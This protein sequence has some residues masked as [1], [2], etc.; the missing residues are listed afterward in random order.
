MGIKLYQEV[1]VDKLYISE[2]QAL[3]GVHVSGDGRARSATLEHGTDPG[4]GE[5]EG[6]RELPGLLQGIR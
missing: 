2:C 6:H 4:H 1:S 3:A 5:G